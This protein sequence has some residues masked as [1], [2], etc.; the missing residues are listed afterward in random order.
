MARDH[1]I[2]RC[3][4]RE[5]EFIEKFLLD[6]RDEDRRELSVVTGNCRQELI[7][8]LE[9]SEDAFRVVEPDG[10]PLV[11]FGNVPQNDGR[12]IWCVATNSIH[13]HERQFALVSRKI[14][15]RWAKMYGR[16]YNCVACFNEPAIRW[17]RW[18]GA[19]FTRPFYVN[20]VLFMRFEI[21]GK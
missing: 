21:R 4:K 1:K 6:M 19:E 9:N 12:L 10:T 3:R 2:E 14:L 13:R 20:G 5:P 15:M 8:S 18:M 7:E 17:L 16:L 11:L